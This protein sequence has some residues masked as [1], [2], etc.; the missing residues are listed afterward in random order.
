MSAGLHR[1]VGGGHNA[2]SRA[3]A[4]ALSAPTCSV[5]DLDLISRGQINPCIKQRRQIMRVSLESEVYEQP[6]KELDP[7]CTAT[8]RRVYRRRHGQGSAL[9]W[10][11]FQQAKTR[12]SRSSSSWLACL[13][14]S[15][16]RSLDPHTRIGRPGDRP[17]APCPAYH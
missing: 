14:S 6:A 9:V 11:S 2:G 8:R 13:L 4:L 17:N 1:L 16:T 15:P 5:G 3:I 10:A 12:R 7:V